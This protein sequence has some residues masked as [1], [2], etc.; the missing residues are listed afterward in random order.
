MKQI[1]HSE[2]LIWQLAIIY[3]VVS[4]FI[5]K[6]CCGHGIT[7]CCLCPLLEGQMFGFSSAIALDPVICL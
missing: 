4:D 1:E 6:N 7:E 5:L 3:R 2:Y